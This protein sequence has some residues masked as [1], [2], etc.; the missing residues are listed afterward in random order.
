MSTDRRTPD[1]RIAALLTAAA[2]PAEAPLPGEAA[3]FAAFRRVHG[4]GP[5]RSMRSTLVA[6][7]LFGALVTV[8][9]AAAAATGTLPVLSTHGHGH[10]NGHSTNAGTDPTLE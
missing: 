3:A 9:G 10:A 1:P 7:A 2:A 8:G 4:T 5:R 6:S